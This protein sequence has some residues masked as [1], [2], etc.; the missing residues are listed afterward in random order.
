VRRGVKM[1][2]RHAAALGRIDVMNDLLKQETNHQLI[3]EAL[4][5][6]CCQ[7]E[8]E[9]ALLLVQSGAK[10]DIFIKPNGS[11]P[12]YASRAT[13]LHMA[14]YHGHTEIVRLLL[15]NGADATLFDPTYN[16]TPAGWAKHG[17]HTEIADL[18]MQYASP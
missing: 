10:G 18:I 8:E 4:I 1:D 11:M 3:E 14:A 15:N 17:G 9:S 12:N 7:G 16:G 6:A 13:A 2:L 5:Y